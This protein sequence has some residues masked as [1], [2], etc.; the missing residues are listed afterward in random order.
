MI[1]KGINKEEVE[2][3]VGVEVEA[4]EILKIS[5][6]NSRVE[7]SWLAMEVVVKVTRV[8]VVGEVEA[9]GDKALISIN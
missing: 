2:A 6:S 9:K 4:E 5:I 3:G 8:E 1:P 7:K